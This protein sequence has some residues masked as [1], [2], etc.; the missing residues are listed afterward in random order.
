MVLVV[1]ALAVAEVAARDVRSG[2]RGLENDR[3]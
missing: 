1:A 3:D 2:A